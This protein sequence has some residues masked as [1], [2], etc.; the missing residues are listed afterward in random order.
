M[1]FLFVL[2]LCTD[3]VVK[4]FKPW[5]TEC[6]PWIFRNAFSETAKFRFLP[7]GSLCWLQIRE[8]SLYYLSQNAQYHNCSFTKCKFLVSS[9]PR[10]LHSFSILC[11]KVLNGFPGRLWECYV[12]IHRRICFTWF[13]SYIFN[14]GSIMFWKYFYCCFWNAFPPIWYSNYTKEMHFHDTSKYYNM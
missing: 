6:S 10:F 2:S 3:V 13:I 5:H 14:H 8:Y 1:P 7:F 4:Y 11:W 9:I 12:I